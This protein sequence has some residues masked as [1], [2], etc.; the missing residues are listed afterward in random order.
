[1]ALFLI[2]TTHDYSNENKDRTSLIFSNFYYFLTKML[3][4]ANAA[5]GINTR[6][7]FNR[8]DLL[9][10]D[11]VN[12]VALFFFFLRSSA[13]IVSRNGDHFWGPNA[14]ATM[15]WKRPSRVR[16]LPGPQFRLSCQNGAAPVVWGLRWTT[17]NFRLHVILN[18]KTQSRQ[19]QM[20]AGILFGGGGGFAQEHTE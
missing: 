4:Y 12:K 9:K 14:A 1:M 13:M 7:G 8:Y 5:V 3:C 10:S 6:I 11:D 20:C 17:A 19:L 15:K 16:F 2:K 18:I